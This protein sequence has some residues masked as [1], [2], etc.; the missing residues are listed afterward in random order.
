MTVLHKDDDDRNTDC[1]RN[2]SLI[3]TVLKDH[4]SVSH[5]MLRVTVLRGTYI[6]AES[7]TKQW[8][9]LI[10]CATVYRNVLFNL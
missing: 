2:N 5:D 6:L 7:T 4:H 10:C 1:L 3:F 9:S 8:T